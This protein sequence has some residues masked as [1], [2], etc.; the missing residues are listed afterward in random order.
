[1]TL[2]DDTARMLRD[3]RGPAG[4]LFAVAAPCVAGPS[5]SRGDDALRKAA[6]AYRTRL[7]TQARRARS[8]S[9]LSEILPAIIDDGDSWHV[10][11]SG[12]VDSLSYLAHIVRSRPLDYVLLSTWC[13]ALSDVQQLGAWID[14]GRIARLDAYVGEIFPNQ[15]GDA[16]E[17]LVPI[18]R[19][20]GGRVCVFRNHSKIF[21]ARAGRCAW[22]IESSANVNTNPRTE[23]T[24]ISADLGLLRHHKDYFDG[25][26]S[27]SRDFDDWRPARP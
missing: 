1:M 24:V 7:R 14:N 25:V 8:E 27:F 23:N 17:A 4:D 11:S 20:T 18:V 13:M 21:L 12:D 6:T 5:R 26:R 3:L 9:A 15:Y 19:A 22:V 2:E 10:I 16:H